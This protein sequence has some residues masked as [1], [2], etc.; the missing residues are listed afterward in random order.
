MANVVIF[1]FFDG[2]D[3][4]DF[5][6]LG[7]SE[8]VPFHY[9][10]VKKIWKFS[11]RIRKDV[12][13]IRNT[14]YIFMIF[15]FSEEFFLDVQFRSFFDEKTQI[16]QIFFKNSTNHSSPLLKKIPKIFDKSRGEG[17]N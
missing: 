2:L 7:I 9:I 1:C 10:K 12:F 8:Y 3:V 11:L 17:Y 13:Y 5:K 4:V 14:Y 16:P 6:K 15:V